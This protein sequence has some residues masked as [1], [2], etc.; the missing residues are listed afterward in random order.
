MA[1]NVAA[2]VGIAST[3]A[4]GH[5]VDGDFRPEPVD[6]AMRRR[7]LDVD[8]TMLTEEHGTDTVVVE[9][10]GQH[11]GGAG[12]ALYTSAKRAAIGVWVGDCAPIAVIGERGV[13]IAHAGW[14]GLRAGVL[15]SLLGVFAAH[16]DR[17]VCCVIGPHIRA[18]CN[19]FGRDDLN[20][21]VERFGPPAR[22]LDAAG[23]PALHIGAVARTFL[24]RHGVDRVMEVESCTKCRPDLHFSHRRGDHGRQ[25]MAIVIDE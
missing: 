9:R 19:E 22:G 18:C 14:R 5:R 7:I 15:E 2:P 16:D 11:D 24:G 8:W 3:I 17:P 13:G 1:A 4:I 23:R 12:D 6:V 10:P 25:V 20:S 21:M